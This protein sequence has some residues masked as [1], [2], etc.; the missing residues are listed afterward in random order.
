MLVHSRDTHVSETLRTAASVLE[1]RS[2]WP[3]ADAPIAQTQSPPRT[4]FCLSGNQ[5]QN[6]AT[7]LGSQFSSRAAPGCS[8]RAEEAVSSAPRGGVFPAAGAHPPEASGALLLVDV[9]EAANHAALE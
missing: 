5:K 3:S 2:A 8:K 4:C 9:D 6:F 1:I 7:T